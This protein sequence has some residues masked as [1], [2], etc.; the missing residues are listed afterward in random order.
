MVSQIELV[1]QRLELQ[2]TGA[3]ERVALTSAGRFVKRV[4]DVTVEFKTG[5]NAVFLRFSPPPE[6]DVK[7]R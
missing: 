6:H 5:I 1:F 3:I 4:V 7:P 2:H